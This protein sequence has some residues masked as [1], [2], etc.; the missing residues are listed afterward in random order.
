MAIVCDNCAQSRASHLYESVENFNQLPNKDDYI[1]G[2]NKN[3]KRQW[4]GSLRI[5]YRNSDAKNIISCPNCKKSVMPESPYQ[6]AYSPKMGKLTPLCED[7]T[8]K[9]LPE[10]KLMLDH[11]KN[12]ISVKK[13]GS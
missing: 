6:I 10:L 11:I 4:A 1:V 13:G 8:Q 2:L 7:C 12:N 3:Q 9:H 5:K